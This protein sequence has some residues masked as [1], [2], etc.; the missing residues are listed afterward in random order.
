MSCQ[1]LKKILKAA[2]NILKIDLVLQV[3]QLERFNPAVTAIQDIVNHPI[4]IESNRLGI[5]KERGTDVSVVLDR[6]EKLAS[7]STNRPSMVL[8][9]L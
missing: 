2:F 3:G 1:G 5:Y 7:P 6:S 9:R 4:F 8:I